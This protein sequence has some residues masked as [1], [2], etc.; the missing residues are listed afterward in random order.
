MMTRGDEHEG[1]GQVPGGMVSG[2]VD[3][4]EELAV[5]YLDGQLDPATTAAIEAHLHDC[6]ACAA[7]LHK[8]EALVAFLEGIDY[9]APPSELEDRVLGEILFPSAGTQTEG[10]PA[11]PVK[12]QE[13][14]WSTV[15]RR[16]IVP[17]VPAAV[18]VIAVLAVVLTYGLVRESADEST[19]TAMNTTVAQSAAA[20]TP[21]EPGL[22]DAASGE[23]MVADAGEEPATESA[24]PRDTATTAAPATTTVIMGAGTEMAF[25][26]ATT[27]TTAVGSTETTAAVAMAPETTTTTANKATMVSELQTGGSPAHFVFEST[28]AKAGQEADGTNDGAGR[29]GADL[30]A[31]LTALTGLEPLDQ[32]LWIDGPTFAAYVPREQAQ[33][34]VDLLLSIGASFQ[35]DV[36]LALQPL[37][38]YAWDQEPAGAGTDA[39][40]RLLEKRAEFVELLASRTPAPAVTR[41]SYTTSTLPPAADDGV[42]QPYTP[43]PDDAGT[44]VLV[45]I[46]MGD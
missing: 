20:K 3:D 40:S 28:T 41:W 29:T 26:A 18:G 12:K 11:Q 35:G 23:T 14:R 15:W 42:E 33:Q 39:V 2:H 4:W 5:D 19:D 13:S 1:R 45:V 34:F 7:R 17:W 10:R 24:P 30:A 21:E 6:P 37:E 32:T 36:G 22:G 9:Q 31:Q 38:V 27:A 8:Q 43:L 44:H 25:P 16:K 46:S